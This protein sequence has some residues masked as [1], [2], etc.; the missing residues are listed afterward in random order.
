MDSLPLFIYN[1]PIVDSIHPHTGQHPPDRSEWMPALSRMSQLVDQF[2]TRPRTTLPYTTFFFDHDSC[3]CPE[4]PNSVREFQYDVAFMLAPDTTIRHRGT[5]YHPTAWILRLGRLVP[6]EFLKASSESTTNLAPYQRL[7]QTIVTEMAGFNHS[8]NIILRL[9]DATW[10]AGQ[11]R[12]GA[13]GVH[14]S[15]IALKFLQ[16]SRRRFSWE[17]YKTHLID[18]HNWLYSTFKISL[19]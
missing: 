4:S 1:A 7:F 5:V 11:Y 14:D 16:G 13:F 6:F 9:K 18:I 3:Y 10:K 2:G 19:G 8:K 12:Q 15:E 17:D